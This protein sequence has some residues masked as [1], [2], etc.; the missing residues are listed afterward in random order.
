VDHDKIV[1]EKQDHIGRER[2]L[3]IDGET[4]CIN[5]WSRISGAASAVT[6]SDRLKRGL[7][8][9]EAVFN[10]TRSKKKKK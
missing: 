3:T 8:T 10:K 7:S 9:K 1:F 5:E 2:Y 4:K 6:I